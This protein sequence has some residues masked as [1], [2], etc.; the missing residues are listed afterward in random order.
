MVT[1]GRHNSNG[2]IY[3]VE[4]EAIITIDLWVQ[5]REGEGRQL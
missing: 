5:Q 2:W 4:G 1:A 3:G